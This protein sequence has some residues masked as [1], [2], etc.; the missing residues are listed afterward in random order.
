MKAYLAQV[1]YSVSTSPRSSALQADSS[2]SRPLGNPSRIFIGPHMSLLPGVFRKGVI[3]ANIDLCV[4][5]CVCV[6]VRARTCK[7]TCT[8]F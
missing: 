1:T 5:V 8:L 7:Q 6:C 2:L 3:F 4:C